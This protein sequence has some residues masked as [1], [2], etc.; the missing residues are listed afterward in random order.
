MRL[1]RLCLSLVLS[2]TWILSLM[3]IA[4]AN[5][6]VATLRVEGATRTIFEAPIVTDGHSVTTAAGGTHKCDGT[7]NAAN[8][9]PGPSATGALDDGAAAQAFTWDGP[10][11]TS[12]EDYFITRIAEDA[13]TDTR[14]WGILLNY[15]FTPVGGCQQ[16]I[17]FGDQ[18]LF[19]FDAFNKQHFLKLTGSHVARTGQPT[20]V[21][22]T[23]GQ[24]GQPIAGATVGPINNTGSATTDAHGKAQVTF[25]NG[26]LKRLKAERADSIRSNALLVLARSS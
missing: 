25:Q 15:Q 20:T 26:G 8:P 11:S 16:R 23:D 4:S 17:H 6:T 21:T 18:V 14:F 2:I 12:F 7:N 10:F 1:S 9:T 19:A 24:T 3:S 22:V 5:P 13:Q